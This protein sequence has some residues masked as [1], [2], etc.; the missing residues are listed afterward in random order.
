MNEDTKRNLP[1]FEERIIAA[2]NELRREMQGEFAALHTRLDELENRVD[3]RL[4]RTEPLW[5]N[6]RDDI[7]LMN[8]KLDVIA[9]DLLTTRAET[10][11]LKKHLPAA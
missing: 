7:R 8:S 2:F 10:T 6:M 3:R 1:S 9:I 4:M 11:T 5:E